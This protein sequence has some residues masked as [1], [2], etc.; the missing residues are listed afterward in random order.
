[1]RLDKLTIGSLKDSPSHQFKNLKNVTI[2]FAQGRWVTVV[3]G[4][5]G[6]G[7]SNVL[8]ALAI[9]FRDLIAKKR[10]PEFAFQLS[11]CMGAGNDK[12]RI[13]IDADPDREK[14]AF[15]IYVTN[16]KENESN[17]IILDA[18]DLD[19]DDTKLSEKPIKLTAF[20]NSDTQY[21]PHYVFSYY[22]G[23]SSRMHEVFRP[24]LESYDSKL[25]NGVD[26]GLKRLFY[27]MPV[28][29]Q[30]VLLAFMIQQSDD[31]REL[32]EKDMGIDPDEGIESVLFVLKQPGWSKRRGNKKNNSD[33]DDRFWGSKGVVQTFLDR[34][35][36][37]AMAPIKVKRDKQITLWNKE[38]TEFQYLF[39][40][41]IQ[42]LRSL[43]DNQSPAQFFRDLES[44]YVSE[45]IEEVRIRVRLKKND[46]S[47]TFRELSEG[48]RQLLTVLGLL[49]FTAEEESLF[50]LDEPDTHL[51]P[52][53]SV[54]YISY[55]KKFI[56]DGAQQ[57]ET[58]HILMTTHNPLA[59]AELER[60]QVQILCMS[61]QEDRSQI[62]ACYP[63]IAPRG[64]GYAA[65]VTSD[66]FGIASTLDQPTQLLL[67]EQRAF[68][69]KETLTLD[70]QHELDSIN[71]KL[72]RLGFRFFHPDDEYSR[73]LRL[74]N[75]LL[76]DRFNTELPQEL[77]KQVVEMPRAE[78][79]ELAK[80]LIAELLSKHPN[81]D[82]GE[83]S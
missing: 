71:A 62:V 20:L 63:E 81:K 59:I 69:A 67:E 64:M 21:L 23:E 82:E 31:V 13:R 60:E 10:T 42:A 51:N 22:S 15:L 75:S 1:M 79:E 46:G 55:L 43:V 72:D 54:D 6:T 50:L 14:D 8:E 73:Y 2:D 53:W 5:N 83:N 49:R 17:N 19:V 56:I 9:I 58:S 12:Q 61:K 80:H 77:A 65:I 34:L 26:P 38:S 40:K 3:I 68:A 57:T 7:K 47:V 25:R 4:W 11:Y 66:M 35:Q 18:Q 48:E 37:I 29:S 41:D 27:A 74:R 45:L 36:N 24:Y 33:G 78:R 16:L 30:F 76:V 52:R 70:E 32:L 39:I 44:T 28:H